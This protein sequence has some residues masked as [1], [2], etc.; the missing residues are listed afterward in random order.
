MKNILVAGG[1]GYIGSHT[2]VEL[3]NSGYNPIIVDNLSN[4]KEESIKR[5]EKIV[6]KQLT[7]YKADVLDKD[8]MRKIFNAHSID[9]VINFAGFKAVGESCQ[10]P[11]EYYHNNI[12]GLIALVEV[13]REFNCKNLVFSSSAT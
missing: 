9:A 11:I 4:S 3:V 12:G 6:N 13:M 2:V 5:V 1:A 7:F 8:A 10:K